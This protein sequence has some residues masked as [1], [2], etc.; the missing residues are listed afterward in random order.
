MACVG[1]FKV[2]LVAAASLVSIAASAEPAP[3]PE[4]RVSAIPLTKVRDAVAR[5]QEVT[6][7]ALGSSSTQGAS[8]S[9]IGQSYPAVLQ[10]EL[11]T[12][13]P[14]AHIAVINRGVGGQDVSEMLPRLERDAI[15]VRPSLVI[16]QVGAN[17]AIRRTDPEVFKRLVSS[18]VQRLRDAHVDVVLMDNQRSPAIMAAPDHLR[19]DNALADVAK[20]HGV[21]LFD[22]GALM[23][24]W[25][26]G[27]NPYEQ[28]VAADGLHH[29]DYGYRCVAKALAAAI[30]DGIREPA[31]A[32]ALASRR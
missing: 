29:N 17:G 8:A 18:G 5:N 32:R 25:R 9:S 22:R 12:A 2:A 16:W 23:D 4:T 27:G 13:L 1:W 20:D 7:V 19:I 31:P 15:G 3:C 28:F 24:Q 30:L 21:A 6:I 14:Q 10:A 26:R 11:Q